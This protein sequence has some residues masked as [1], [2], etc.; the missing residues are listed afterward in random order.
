[1]TVHWKMFYRVCAVLAIAAVVCSAANYKEEFSGKVVLVMGGT[2]GI[3][4]QTALKFAQNGAHVIFTARDDH[5]TWYNG[6]N[7]VKKISE[8]PIVMQTHG[9]IR[10]VK[11]DITNLTQVKALFEDIRQHENDLDFAV[12]SAGIIGARFVNWYDI[13]PFINGKYDPMRNN[14]YGTVFSI[15]YET[16]FMMEKNH[17]GAIVSLS[18]ADGLMA[19][20]GVP[21][22]GTSKWGIVGLTRGV[23]DAFAKNTT[24]RPFIRVN[25]IA[26]TL[27]NTSLSWQQTKWK[28]DHKTQP[29][30]GDYVTPASAVWKEISPGWIDSLVGKTIVPP[31]SIADA[32][33]FLCSSDA[34]Y[35]TGHILRVDRG[36]TA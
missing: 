3:G 19:C 35:M 17:S 25:A 12:N 26:P 30:E 1:M 7:T 10:F 33:L 4:Y 6:S 14:I 36:D 21:L 18:S 22:Y 8:D 29:W 24:E 34:S 27:V 5:P 11:T 2:S 16:R 13:R 9:T 20:S 32:V 31:Q 15:M 23:A 28:H